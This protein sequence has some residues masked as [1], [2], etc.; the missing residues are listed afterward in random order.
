MENQ[1]TREITTLK[2]WLMFYVLVVLLSII[3]G[4]ALIAFIGG[5]FWK[6]YP[7]LKNYCRALLVV[8]VV[9]I[10]LL[11][12]FASSLF[13]SYART[14]KESRYTDVVLA[15]DSVKHIVELCYLDTEDLNQCSNIDASGYYK[16]SEG[17]NYKLRVPSYY[18]GKHVDFV[19]VQNGVVTAQAV[20]RA[21]LYGATYILKPKVLS[22]GYLEWH[23]SDESSCLLYR[24]C[25]EEEY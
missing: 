24:L 12:I 25:H 17:M 5:A 19:V 1:Q 14:F 16:E 6:K 15:A 21:G 9:C 2:V 3:P 13:P 10:I 18:G 22:G 20:K 23:L 4:A 8:W 11:M 7:S